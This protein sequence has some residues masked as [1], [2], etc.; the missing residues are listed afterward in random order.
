MTRERLPRSLA[1]KIARISAHG[2]VLVISTFLGL[3][4]GL[5]LD[6]LTSMA[7]NFTLVGLILGIVLG[8]KGFIQEA[9]WERRNPS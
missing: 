7:P 5:E 8:F 9:I 2:F 3:Y 4:L 1:H 6:Q